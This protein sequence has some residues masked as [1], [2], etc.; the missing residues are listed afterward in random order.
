[1]TDT[2]QAHWDH[3][4]DTKAG[5]VL[6]GFKSIQRKSPSA[7]ATKPQNRAGLARVLTKDW[8]RAPRR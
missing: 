3:I 1:M 8:R 4:Y 7:R 6:S 2:T 5:K